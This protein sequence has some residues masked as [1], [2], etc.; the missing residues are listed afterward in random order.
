MTIDWNDPAARARHI[1]SVGIDAYNRDHAEHLERSAI[2]TIAGHAI[3][4]T[5]SA[6]GKLFI[7]GSTGKAFAKLAVAADY[8]RRNP[9][10]EGRA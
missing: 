9:A 3:R 6:F 1:E 8:A 10:G 7:V 5:Q 2:A 4:P